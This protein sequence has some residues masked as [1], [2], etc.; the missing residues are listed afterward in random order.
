MA[1]EVPMALIEGYSFYTFFVLLVTNLGGPTET[2]NYLMKSE[3]KLLF[4]CCCPYDKKRF[5]TKATWNLF[6]FL[7]TR[8]IVVFLSVI[9]FYADTK[10][11][12]LVS[13]LL[14]LVA[15]VQLIYG[16]LSVINLFEDVYSFTTNLNGVLKLLLLKM[17]V[18]LITIEGIIVELMNAFGANPYKENN[19]YSAED[20]LQ[21]NYCALVLIEFTLMAFV[22]YFAFGR[23]ITMPN[24]PY[25]S[26]NAERSNSGKHSNPTM[27]WFLVQVFSFSDVF[28]ILA[29]ED[30]Q[31]MLSKA[32]ERA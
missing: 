13:V 4:Y 25:H 18:G 14:S 1:M 6:H 16:V 26:Y 5:Y 7:F 20:R 2:V 27:W 22:F 12:K 9:C 3:K 17:S 28:G 10:P 8:V 15:L 30:E 31:G 19:E 24:T 11:A 21:R 29:L 23:K 32:E